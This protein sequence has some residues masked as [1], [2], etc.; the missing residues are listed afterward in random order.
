MYVRVKIQVYIHVID[1]DELICLPLQNNISRINAGQ[2]TRNSKQRLYA[3]R[4]GCDAMRRSNG[5]RVSRKPL[6]LPRFH[7]QEANASYSHPQVND[8]IY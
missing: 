7:A 4:Q 1:A 2:T 6:L 5:W 8:D 3:M